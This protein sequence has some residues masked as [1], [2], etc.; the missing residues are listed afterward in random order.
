[1]LTTCDI[2]VFY[3]Q[4]DKVLLDFFFPLFNFD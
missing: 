3:I 2:S 4:A 1:M